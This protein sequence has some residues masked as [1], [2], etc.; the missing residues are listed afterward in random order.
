MVASDFAITQEVEID[1]VQ[2]IVIEKENKLAEDILPDIVPQ[3]E[4]TNDE[5][6]LPTWV[7][8][9]LPEK[10]IEGEANEEE[11]RKEISQIIPQQ[12]TSPDISMPIV[13]TQQSSVALELPSVDPELVDQAG[14][15]G[16]LQEDDQGQ[17][18][19]VEIVESDLPLVYDHRWLPVLSSVESANVL[20]WDVWYCSLIARMNLQR[21]VPEYTIAY[22]SLR[23]SWY[24]PKWHAIDLIAFGWEF[25][26]LENVAHDEMKDYLD[27]SS[28]RLYDMYMYRPFGKGI[29]QDDIIALSQDDPSY[30]NTYADYQAQG[31]RVVIFKASNDER[32][33]LDPLRWR[34]TVEPQLLQVYIDYSRDRDLY[35]IKDPDAQKDLPEADLWWSA[36]LL[37]PYMRL[38]P[39]FVVLDEEQIQWPLLQCSSIIVCEDVDTLS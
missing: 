29:T 10:N 39:F 27:T 18:D 23:A 35:V 37:L 36:V 13:I 21:F 31:H 32:Y 14:L 30:K 19:R 4:E 28:D 11:Q 9:Q 1:G 17:D 15:L 24:I 26:M 5:P 16:I 8:E 3:Q 7:Q 33:V 38:F 6:V 34:K 22:G 25:D 12:K 20:W 2:V